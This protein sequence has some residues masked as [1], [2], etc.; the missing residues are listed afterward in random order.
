[1]DKSEKDFISNNAPNT[2]NF[3]KFGT[4]SFL[5][6]IF[7]LILMLGIYLK[8]KISNYMYKRRKLIDSA[9]DYE[10]K[11]NSRNDLKVILIIISVSLL[12]G[13]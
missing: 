10:R 12:L 1:M 11:R 6:A 4:Y 2:F 13:D 8:K 3:D 5:F 9:E 7:I